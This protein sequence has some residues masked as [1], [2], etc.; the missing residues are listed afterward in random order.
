MSK[1]RQNIEIGI[2]RVLFLAFNNARVLLSEMHLQTKNTPYA[3][4]ASGTFLEDLFHHF[5][6]FADQQE[7]LLRGYADG[8]N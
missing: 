1:A 2:P 6:S 4:A 3:R 8:I 5:L 7:G